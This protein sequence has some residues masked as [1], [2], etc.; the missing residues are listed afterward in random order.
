VVGC[1]AEFFFPK[2]E[3]LHVTPLVLPISSGAER[4]WFERCLY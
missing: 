2:P 1:S 3:V 4:R